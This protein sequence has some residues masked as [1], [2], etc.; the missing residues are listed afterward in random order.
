MRVVRDHTIRHA[1]VTHCR[2]ADT[3]RLPAVRFIFSHLTVRSSLEA[4]GFKPAVVLPD[5]PLPIY[6]ILGKCEDISRL[7]LVI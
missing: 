7:E 6:L 3:M 1:Y 5:S 2:E 4:E